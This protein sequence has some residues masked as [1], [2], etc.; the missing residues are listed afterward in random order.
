HRLSV[1]PIHVPPLR[2]RQGDIALLAG[3]FAERFRRKLGLQQLILSAS[4]IDML[5]AYHWPGN[6][7]ELEHVISRAALFAKADNATGITVISSAH[8]TGLQIDNSSQEKIQNVE[9]P[10]QILDKQ[11]IVDLRLETETYQRNLIRKALEASNGNWTKAAQQ[12]SMDRANL[13]RL[14]KRLGI[15]VAKEVRI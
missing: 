2:D 12:L 14:A 13:A 5:E 1:F 10:Q 8:L 9:I 7:R 3:F 6:V 4:A 15:V 11:E